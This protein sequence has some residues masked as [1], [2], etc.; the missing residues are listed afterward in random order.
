MA[1]LLNKKYRKEKDKKIVSLSDAQ[2]KELA[3]V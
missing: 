2:I 3:Q 1:K